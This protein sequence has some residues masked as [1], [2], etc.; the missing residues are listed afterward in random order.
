MYI[1]RSFVLA[2]PTIKERELERERDRQTE[3]G[4]WEEKVRE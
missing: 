4:G 3:T 2:P 1:L